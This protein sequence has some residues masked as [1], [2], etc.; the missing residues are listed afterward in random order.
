MPDPVTQAPSSSSH[1]P[2]PDGAGHASADPS[3][4]PGSTGSRRP[5][6]PVYEPVAPYGS[7]SWAARE[8]LTDILR[9]Q[10]LGPVGGEDELLPVAPDTRYLIGRIAPTRLETWWVVT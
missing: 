1:A 7:G 9:R 2:G 6:D 3:A 10:L 5:D 4:R 8:N